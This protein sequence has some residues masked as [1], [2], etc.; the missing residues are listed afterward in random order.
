MILI[1]LLCEMFWSFLF[2]LAVC[3]FGQRV[4]NAFIE[5]DSNI[6]QLDWYLFSL[7]MQKML[8]ILMIIAQKPVRLDVFGN[9]SCD[10]EDFKAVSEILNKMKISLGYVVL[11]IVCFKVVNGGFSYFTLLRKFIN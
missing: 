3:E 11:P 4:S 6:D 8:I 5:I 7:E 10:R 1:M 2:V 9:I